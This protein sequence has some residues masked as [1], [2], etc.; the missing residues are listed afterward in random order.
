MRPIL[1]HIG[2]RGAPA[3]LVLALASI[4]L[5]VWIFTRKPEGTK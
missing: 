2:G 4:A 5:L 3:G 1:A